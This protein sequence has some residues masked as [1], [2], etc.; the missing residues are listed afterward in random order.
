MEWEKY[1]GKKVFIKLKSGTVYHGV[2]KEVEKENADL[3]WIKITDRFDMEVTFVHS[4]ILQM[5]ELK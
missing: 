3:I 1:I 4:E 2:V 5:E